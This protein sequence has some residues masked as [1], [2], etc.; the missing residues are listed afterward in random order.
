MDPRQMLKVSEQQR[1]KRNKIIIYKCKNGHLKQAL[2]G[3]IR[4][5]RTDLHQMWRN[6]EAKRCNVLNADLGGTSK[7]TGNNF[8][9][10]AAMTAQPKISGYK[11]PYYQPKKFVQ[12]SSDD[13]VITI[14][15]R[16]GGE[17]HVPAEKYYRVKETINHYCNKCKGKE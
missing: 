11:N 14:C 8:V 5:K 1:A 4:R 12:L 2:E 15:K 10:T 3:S 6:D 13:I 7:P 9:Q 16:C 17:V